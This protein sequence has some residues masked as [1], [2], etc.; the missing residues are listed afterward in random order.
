MHDAII[1]TQCGCLSSRDVTWQTTVCRNLSSLHA[2]HKRCNIGPNCLET[3]ECSSTYPA[4]P[5]EPLQHKFWMKGK[6]NERCD[7][8]RSSYAPYSSPRSSSY[9]SSLTDSAWMD[10]LSQA[11]LPTLQVIDPNSSAHSKCVANTILIG[12]WHAE[13]L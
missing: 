6:Q 1:C 10:T 12:S 5:A 3:I 8:C 7:T 13:A 9:S 2:Q 11:Q 4:G